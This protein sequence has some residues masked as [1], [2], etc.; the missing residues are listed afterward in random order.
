MTA[1]TL[2]ELLDT[3]AARFGP[4][5]AVAS[6]EGLRTARFS[7]AALHEAAGAMAR[8]IADRP[9]VARGDRVLLWAPNGRRTVAALFGLFRA[10]LVA[11]PLDQGSTLDFVG[12]VAR[13][14]GARLAIVPRGRAVPDGIAPIWLDDLPI[15]GPGS[16]APPP[17][18]SDLAQ[19][20][21]TSGTTGAPK[22][23]MLT[24]ANIMA[25]LYASARVVPA[26]AD[27]H[28]LSLLPLS[29]MFEQT[30]GL[31]LPLLNGGS[32]HYLPDLRPST[33]LRILRRRR[34][35]GMVVVPRV[36]QLM[37]R[38]LEGRARST[39][40]GRVWSLQN[41]LAA[42]LGLPLRRLVFHPVHRGLGGRL[43][44]LLCGGAALPEAIALAWERLGIRVIEGYGATECAPVLASN[45]FDDRCPGTVGRALQGV[46]LRLSDEGE[47]QAK[48]ANVFPGYW[49]DPE[50]TAHAFTPDGWF[51]TGDIARQDAQG[52]FA[53]VGR[54]SDRIVLGSGMKVHPED[55]EDA[56]RAAGIPDC[57]VVGRPGPDGQDQVHAVLRAVD[58]LA[59]GEIARAVEAANARLAPHQRISGV[60]LWPGDFPRTALQKVRRSALRAA[61]GAP[62]AEAPTA[63]QLGD[64]GAILR[65]VA[66]GYTGPISAGTRIAADLG[67]DSLGLMEVSGLI[68]MAT[69]RILSDEAIA[70]LQT[71]AD[72]QRLMEPTG[73]TQ[74]QARFPDWPRHPLAVAVRRLLQ[75]A[76]LFPLHRVFARPFR[77]EG[78]DLIGSDRPLLIIANHA[79]HADTVSI[80]RALPPDLRHRTS[81]AAAADYFYATRL[82][83]A[84]ASLVLNTFPFAR[85]GQ[86]RDSLERC[87]ELADAGWSILIYPE[88]TRSPDGRLL[89]F[90]RGIALLAAGLGVDIVPVAVSGGADVLPK[91]RF[92]PRRAPVC[93]RFGAPL[94]VAPDAPVEP[95]VARLQ[96]SVAG[97]MTKEGAR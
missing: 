80:L 63:D 95:T 74:G 67:I 5:L 83:G 3:S 17:A 89:P 92:W 28:F 51:R 49:Q 78:R 36:L 48:G 25:D 72:L 71:V 82:G 43:A 31:Y 29:H 44:F 39:G 53:I 73:D 64:L 33:L 6:R 66:P 69:G 26:S 7:Y 58:A 94:R 96:A 52:R 22:G 11:V 20:V 88:G 2:T 81:A 77:V 61:L 14:T 38:T 91:G 19:I 57:A 90:K 55:V 16:P 10:G 54:L 75:A 41:R 47:L 60:T 87:G 15:A 27:L 76:L 34:P 23:A 24:H 65:Q 79:S 84:V 86:V 30:A 59:P 40:V 12:S 13:Q 1:A 4:R 70:A 46:T 8:Q 97:L 32:V 68:E 21:Y 85:Q 45:R 93:V 9:G 50:R 62:A 56:L 37:M 42:P 35:T 18:P